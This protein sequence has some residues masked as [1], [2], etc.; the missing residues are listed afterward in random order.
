M[1]FTNKN[2]ILLFAILVTLTHSG[3]AQDIVAE[4]N[5][6]TKQKDT[7]KKFKRIKLDGI[8][9]TIGDYVILDSEID[10]ALVEYAQNEQN[11]KMTRCEVLGMLME[12]KLY[13]HHAIQDSIVIN[14]SEIMSEVEEK[15]SVLLE[16]VGPMEKII[17]YY[18]QKS[19]EE[20][21]ST[22]FDVLKQNRLTSEMQKKIVDAVEIT[23][24]E[25]RSFFN[26]IPEKDRPIIGA[27]VEVSQII[28]QPKVED[29]EKQRV[30]NKL[31]DIKRDVLE[32]GASFTAKA[33]F[34][35]ED[36]G[37]RS[38]GGYYKMTRKTNFVKEFKE[39]AFSL[40]QGEISEPFET[41]FGFH[42]IYLEKIRG[43]ELDLRHIL[44]IPKVSDNAMKEAKEKANLIKKRIEAG[45]IS[46]EE[47]AR[48]MSDEKETRA[49][50]GVFLNPRTLDKRFELTKMDPILYQQISNLKQNEI[51]V[52][53]IDEDQRGLKR[54]KLITVKQ[55]TD[56]HVADY[57]KDYARIKEFALKEKQLEVI[58]KWADEK[59]KDTYIKINGQYRECDF[60]HNW[61]KK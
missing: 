2:I 42:I 48:S 52:P 23:P 60:A 22:F 16:R 25:V 14:D 9:S 1:K 8:V 53:L 50:G 6:A 35:T 5:V 4:S 45:E 21:R 46:F 31:K 11:V 20:F 40:A 43:Q 17:K 3:F 54:Y 56:E 41:E 15:I 51:S 27:E 59:I 47:A 37:T 29:A 30:I 13:A 36:P 61:F 28:I 34:N 57:A 39:V 44:I 33:V 12:N 19:E 55:K 7:L 49:N 58:S 38:N 24:D 26:N 18:N 32:N 10:I